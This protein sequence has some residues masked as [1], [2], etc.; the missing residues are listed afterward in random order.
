MHLTERGEKV[1]TSR[2]K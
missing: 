1:R 2:W